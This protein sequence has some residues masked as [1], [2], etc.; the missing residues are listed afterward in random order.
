MVK[1][2]FCSESVRF[3]CQLNISLYRVLASWQSPAAQRWHTQ[4]VKMAYFDKL[5]L[6]VKSGLADIVTCEL[7]FNGPKF[8]KP[9]PIYLPNPIICVWPTGSGPHGSPLFLFLKISANASQVPWA[10]RKKGLFNKK[11]WRVT[12]TPVGQVTLGHYM[13]H[14]KF[15]IDKR[16]L[17]GSTQHAVFSLTDNSRPQRRRNTPAPAKAGHAG[18]TRTTE[19]ERKETIRI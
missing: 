7:P 11:A 19:I 3:N 5:Y 1:W 13:A 18:N 12:Y 16:G 9:T 4:A 10:Y 14:S 17:K 8:L 15:C 6:L 2:P